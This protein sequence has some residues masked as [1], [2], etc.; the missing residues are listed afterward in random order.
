MEISDK[1]IKDKLTQDFPACCGTCKHL[2]VS[3]SGE[4]YCWNDKRRYLVR[5][6][7]IS[8]ASYC[9]FYERSYLL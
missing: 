7:Q 8:K 6:F 2:H 9:V 3:Q 5:G 4:L 1:E